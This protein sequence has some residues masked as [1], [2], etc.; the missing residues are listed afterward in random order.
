MADAGDSATIKFFFITPQDLSITRK[1]L[2]GLSYAEEKV[3][4]IRNT[5]KIGTGEVGY[6]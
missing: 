4:A 5:P 3:S 1:N 2:A 6:S